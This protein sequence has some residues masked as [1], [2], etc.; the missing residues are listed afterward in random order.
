[1][2]YLQYHCKE[3]RKGL[4][5]L[6]VVVMVEKLYQYTQSGFCKEGGKGR[7][8]SGGPKKGS[9]PLRLYSDYKK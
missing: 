7:R 8:G 1:M 6:M 5:M 3:G 9:R 4:D 2:K